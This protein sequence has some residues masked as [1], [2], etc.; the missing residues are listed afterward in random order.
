MEWQ[1]VEVVGAEDKIIQILE[2][3]LCKEEIYSGLG[4]GCKMCGMPVEKRKDFC[5]SKC[6][7]KYNNINKLKD[8][9]KK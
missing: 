9:E 4:E 2:C 8:S 6:R 5:S 3:P 1:V 7:I